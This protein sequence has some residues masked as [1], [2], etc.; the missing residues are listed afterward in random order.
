MVV[1]TRALRGA[2][3]APLD[4][5]GAMG[6]H[7][8]SYG[9]D[10]CEWVGLGTWTP[11]PSTMSALGQLVEEALETCSSGL[12]KLSEATGFRPGTPRVV[13]FMRAAPLWLCGRQRRISSTGEWPFDL[14]FAETFDDGLP[15]SPSAGWGLWL[16]SSLW[17]GT[18]DLADT[19]APALTDELQRQLLLLARW[20]R[21]LEQVPPLA[22]PARAVAEATFAA[23]GDATWFEVQGN[24]RR[25]LQ[26]P[27][28]LQRF[29]ELVDAVPELGGVRVALR[30]AVED[31]HAAASVL[32]DA[33]AP[34]SASW[35]PDALVRATCN[36]Q[37]GL[38]AALRLAGLALEDVSDHARTSWWDRRDLASLAALSAVDPQVAL[39][40]ADAAHRTSVHLRAVLV[41]L[42]AAVPL[43]PLDQLK[44]VCW[45]TVLLLEQARNAN[46]RSERIS[47]PV[48][49]TASAGAAAVP[50]AEQAEAD[51]PAPVEEESPSPDQ[52]VG[53]E[54]LV[55][56]VGQPA[57]VAAVEEAADTIRRGARV[58]LL[59]VGPEGVGVRSCVEA[60]GAVLHAAGR[61]HGKVTPVASALVSEAAGAFS[62]VAGKLEKAFGAALH[63]PDLGGW[64][65]ADT[66]AG[67]GGVDAL[68]AA[69][70]DPESGLDLVVAECR[71]SELA[72]LLAAAP[73][74]LRKFTVVRTKDLSDEELL[75]VGAG[76]LE[77]RG[78]AME[79][80]ATEAAAE[81]LRSIPG[82]GSFANARRVEHL[83]DA[84]VAHAAAAG[85]LEGP[86][87]RSDF[88]LVRS[89]MTIAR[90]SL[91]VAL[92]ELDVLVGLRDVKARIRHLVQETEFWE[93][94]SRAGE[95]VLSPTRHLA[96][97]GAP[98]TAKT[99]LARIIARTYN[100]LG[101]LRTGI[102]VEATRA[103]LVAQYVGQTAPKVRALVDRA[104]GGVLFIDEAYALTR[105]AS[106]RDFG[107]E[108]VAELV[109]LMEDRRDDLVVI[110]AGYEREMSW[111]LGSNPGLASRVAET[112]HVKNYTM[113]ELV[114][115]FVSMAGRDK[116]AV[117]PEAVSALRATIEPLM[118]ETGFANGRTVRNLYEQ[119]VAALARRAVA[120]GMPTNTIVESDLE[121]GRR[122]SPAN[123]TSYGLYL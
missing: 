2:A 114:Q 75:V 110:F 72:A 68:V 45:D 103:D 115:I 35:G 30:R 106:D 105:S 74:L 117:E 20:Y 12:V 104:S 112:I 99:T 42:N 50:V 69:L 51:G 4:S 102:L 15:K 21:L 98:G 7:D 14:L 5:W 19:N 38:D 113:D 43:Q 78:M 93:A 77:A 90:P 76:L 18:E 10:R 73:N 121:S 46:R 59:V 61:G 23:A 95:L 100:A 6:A 17:F 36:G 63:L 101:V 91:E 88:E 107:A 9:W 57:L 83:F 71:P 37:P 97:T 118:N 87:V 122:S 11:E 41:D 66:G 108:A 39:V 53:E 86:L 54:S 56:L 8:T 120:T 26:R 47:V 33:G 85:R 79:V 64:P 48:G 65:D 16:P 40:W 3:C 70:N 58:R 29:P 1:A 24:Y 81:A 116:F 92:E 67:R 111:F 13:R 49:P 94:R 34:V 119:A 28:W 25:V 22:R 32:V 31:M 123:R 109:K 96:L 27:K 55:R 82:N 80:D 44:D 62:R 89:P 60:L 84:A 52:E